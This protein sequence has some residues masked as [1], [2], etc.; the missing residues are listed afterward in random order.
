MLT[1]YFKFS[2]VFASVLFFVAC[3]DG[4]NNDANG[5]S[6]TVQNSDPVD[7]AK[8]V[9]DNRLADS[10]ESD[11]DYLV[12]AAHL[13]LKEVES[14]KW[15]QKHAV[16]Q[17]AKNFASMM[18]TEHTAM[19][20]KVKALAAQ[21]NITLPDSLPHNEMEN[22]R[23]NDKKGAD[24][25]RD[26]MSMMV[27]DHEKAI[28]KFERAADKAQDGDIKKLFVDGLPSLKKHLAMAKTAKDK[29]DKSKDS[30]NKDNSAQ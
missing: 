23:S 4:E 13:G 10:V 26:Y 21:K 6:A 24:F 22:I 8:E 1:K 14:S 9:N 28:D 15:A 5:D 30:N 20:K 27:D 25:D 16:S 12:E 19:N 18:V 2:I 17:T 29:V 3:N 7:S 11:A